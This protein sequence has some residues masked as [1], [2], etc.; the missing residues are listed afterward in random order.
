V[1]KGKALYEFTA[2][3][4]WGKQSGKSAKSRHLEGMRKGMMPIDKKRK[5][6]NITKKD[7]KDM[8]VQIAKMRQSKTKTEN[9]RSED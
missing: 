5:M 2:E 4:R 6:K 1:I 9:G 7:S 3:I 8:E